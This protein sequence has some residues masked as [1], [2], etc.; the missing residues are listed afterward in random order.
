MAS[1]QQYLMPAGRIKQ[2][3]FHVF[4]AV[5][6][7]V[8]QGVVQYHQCWPAGFPQQIGIGQAADKAHLFPG[9]K[10]QFGN[11][12]QFAAPAEGAGPE[13]FVDFQGGFGE[14]HRQVMVEVL[15][16]RCLQAACEGLA[17]FCEQVQQQIQGLGAAVQFLIAAIAL[18][19]LRLFL[20]EL[21][22]QPFGTPGFKPDFDI[23]ELTPAVFLGLA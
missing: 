4:Q 18:V 20:I 14:K 13:L 21:F 1:K 22:F 7:T 9:A 3:A 16:Q 23:P 8:H 12:P 11:L 6:V 10:T 17:F 2:D 15:L 5:A 19:V